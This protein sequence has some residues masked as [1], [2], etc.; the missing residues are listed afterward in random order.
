MWLEPTPLNW[1]LGVKLYRLINTYS[2][3]FNFVFKHICFH[4]VKK[5]LVYNEGLFW[6]SE[7]CLT[8]IILELHSYISLKRKAKNTKRE[9]KSLLSW[10]LTFQTRPPQL[11]L[12]LSIFLSNSLSISFRPSVLLSP[13]P[14][15]HITP[16]I[17]PQ[18]EAN[19]RECA[20]CVCVCVCLHECD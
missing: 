4:I 19:L 20:Q 9:K 1:P 18:R 8:Y 12:Q 16:L 11:P 10:S 17:T 3:G 5:P 15:S 2:T 7:S 14:P 13:T 6:L